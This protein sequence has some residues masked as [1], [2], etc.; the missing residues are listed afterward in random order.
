MDSLTETKTE[1]SNISLLKT[2]AQDYDIEKGLPVG[3]R[4]K[5]A[6]RLKELGLANEKGEIGYLNGNSL[7]SL[8]K[9][10]VT[11]TT[12][13]ASFNSL[14]AGADRSIHNGINYK[15]LQLKE[16]SPW[17]DFVNSIIDIKNK[18]RP[19][20]SEISHIRYI[21]PRGLNVEMNQF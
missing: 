13:L 9:W 3:V 15:K 14:L 2:F 18:S 12:G 16:V 20:E 19:P 6:D 11:D 4:D 5:V 8:I 10:P 17:Y 1:T 7:D 21:P